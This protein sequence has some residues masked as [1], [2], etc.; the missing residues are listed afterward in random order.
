MK[1]LHKVPFFCWF[2]INLRKKEGFFTQQNF[3]SLKK[4]RNVYPKKLQSRRSFPVWHTNR[5]LL[6]FA[7]VFPLLHTYPPFMS[8]LRTN[9]VRAFLWKWKK[10]N[11]NAPPSDQKKW[12]DFTKMRRGKTAAPRENS[13]IA[14][15]D[16]FDGDRAAPNRFHA[17]YK[18]LFVIS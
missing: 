9:R 14:P 5:R 15:A 13:A 1:D 12:T 7:P 16:R 18:V 17:G 2:F 11:A 10:C 6:L 4:Q 8:P 3:T